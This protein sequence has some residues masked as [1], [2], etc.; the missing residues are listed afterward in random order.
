AVPLATLEE[1]LSVAAVSGRERTVWAPSGPHCSDGEGFAALLREAWDASEIRPHLQRT[2][3]QQVT[4]TDAALLPRGCTDVICCVLLFLAIVG[5]V[6]VGIV[7]WTHGD[8]RKVIYPTDSRGEFCGQ[9][10]TKN[11]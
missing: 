11:A 9:K 2:H 5:Y 8:P 4:C 7:A 3:L 10:G 1:L 6:A